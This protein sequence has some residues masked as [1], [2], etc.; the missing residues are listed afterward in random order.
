MRT[1]LI[2][3]S[4]ERAAS[5]GDPAADVYARVFAAHPAMEKLFVRD[6]DGSVRGHMFQELV[7]A[8]LDYVGPNIYGGN[9][10]RIE[11]TNH[12]QLGVPA[13]VYPLIFNALRDTLRDTQADEWGPDV[14]AA[15]SKLLSDLDALLKKG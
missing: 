6:K 3:S 13:D 15:W 12:E 4:L 8:L 10:F 5:E 1:D 11:H 9:L 14:D 2:T 7:M